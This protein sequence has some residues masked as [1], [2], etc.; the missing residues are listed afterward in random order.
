MHTIIQSISNRPRGG[1][2]SV[3]VQCS[4]RF[5]SAFIKARWASEGITK[6][7]LHEK[8]IEIICIHFA[9]QVWNNESN[10]AE[11]LALNP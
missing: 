8:T 9:A 4:I 6:A 5:G 3:R 7:S 11:I 10:W 2:R 1:V